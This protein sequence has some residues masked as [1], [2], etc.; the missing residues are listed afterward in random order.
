[1]KQTEEKSV[2]RER[3]MDTA[4]RLYARKGYNAVTLRDIAAEIG[5]HHLGA[6]SGASDVV[7]VSK[8]TSQPKS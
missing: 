4:E 1:M 5:I 6:A 2:A 3:V 8:L 7:I